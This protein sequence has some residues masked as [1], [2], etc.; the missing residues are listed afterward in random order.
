MSCLAVLR[1]K[2]MM[3][4]GADTAFAG[5]YKGKLYRLAD[6]WQKISIVGGKLIFC[7]GSDEVIPRV[8]TTFL[9]SNDQ[10]M[11]NLARIAKFFNECYGKGYEEDFGDNTGVNIMAGYFENGQTVLCHINPTNNYAPNFVPLDEGVELYRYAT[12]YHGTEFMKNTDVFNGSAAEYLQYGFDS[13]ADEGVGGYVISY[14][15]DKYGILPFVNLKINEPANLLRG[16]NALMQK[17]ETPTITDRLNSAEDYFK[18]LAGDLS[19]KAIDE[20]GV[21]KL[22]AGAINVEVVLNAAEIR[23]SSNIDIVNNATVG[24][25]VILSITD[26]RAG[27]QWGTGDNAPA[28]YYDPVANSITIGGSVDSVWAKGQRIDVPPVAV[29][30]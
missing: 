13:I 11:D 19:G 6:D 30:G 17:L 12:G 21:E 18:F 2:D 24:R 3:I 27:V 25:K 8:L 1:N 5:K 7:A 15:M 29:F 16:D 10:S 20:P 14:R 23:S 9:H 28:V 26:F 4:W 22:R